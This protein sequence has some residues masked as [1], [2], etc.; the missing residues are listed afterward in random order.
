MSEKKYKSG[1]AID[2]EI[3]RLLEAKK[4]MADE[5][6]D[7][8]HRALEN[9][10]F[11]EQLVNLTDTEIKSIAKIIRSEFDSIVEKAKKPAT[12]KTQQTE[13]YETTQTETKLNDFRSLY[14]DSE[15]K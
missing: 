13:I 15:M 14:R 4:Q 12:E 9:K 3:T 6:I 10:E 11:R 5:K 7:T 1:S 8:F 2:A